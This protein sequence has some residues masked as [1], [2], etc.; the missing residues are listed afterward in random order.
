M[1]VTKRSTEEEVVLTMSREEYDRLTAVLKACT[2][3]LY[4][5][6]RQEAARTLSLDDTPRSSLGNLVEQVYGDF[7][8]ADM[9]GPH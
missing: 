3:I 6:D 9:R 1:K 2:S 5:I 8:Y 4:G 7:V